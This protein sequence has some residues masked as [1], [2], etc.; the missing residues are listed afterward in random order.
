MIGIF[1]SL[2]R[3]SILKRWEI[4][5]TAARNNKLSAS[6]F[7]GLSDQDPISRVQTSWAQFFDGESHALS[8]LK[9]LQ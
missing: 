7:K 3:T 6:F 8:G 1:L 2:S 9:M 5:S 4:S